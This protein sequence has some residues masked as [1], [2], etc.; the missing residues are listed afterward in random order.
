MVSLHKRNVG[1][2]HSA[3]RCGAKT[4]SGSPCQSPMI[5]G[6]KRC[7]MHG[8]KGSGAPRNNRH[9]FKT[10][11]HTAA[12]EARKREVR[13]LD[14]RAKILAKEIEIEAREAARAASAGRKSTSPR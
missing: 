3:A 1:P 10:G 12:M 7:R 13:T 2:M 11:L 6:G 4:R 5:A 8:G 14:R 9:A